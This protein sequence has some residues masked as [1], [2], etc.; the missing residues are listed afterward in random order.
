MSDLSVGTAIAKLLGDR[1]SKFGLFDREGMRLSVVRH[2][3]SYYNLRGMKASA[4]MFS[5]VITAFNDV[6]WSG[7]IDVIYADQF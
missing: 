2:K 5:A 7:K 1:I 4:R 3:L 6:G